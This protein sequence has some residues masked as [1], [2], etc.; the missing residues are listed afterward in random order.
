[1]QLH[2]LVKL[3]GQNRLPVY[4]VNLVEFRQNV[5]KKGFIDLSKIKNLH[6]QKHSISYGCS[7]YSCLVTD[8]ALLS[9]YPALTFLI[10]SK[11][12]RT[13]KQQLKYFLLRA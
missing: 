6:P 2:N 8:I 1:M 3:F 12:N 13:N 4:F 10:A 9:A 5:G 7:C 11:N